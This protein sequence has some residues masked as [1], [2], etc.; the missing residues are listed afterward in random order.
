MNRI[1]AST[2]RRER[3]PLKEAPLSIRNC[4]STFAREAGVRPA[5]SRHC[6]R[7]AARTPLSQKRDGKA[8]A[9]ATIERLQRE[10]AV[11][12]ARVQRF[13]RYPSLFV[14][15]GVSPIWTAGSDSYISKLIELAG[16]LN[17]AGD[18]HAAYGQYSTEAL[19]RDQPD[20]LVVDPATRLDS[21][22]DREPWRSLRAVQRHQVYS[23]NPDILERPGAR[24]NEGLRWLLERIEPLAR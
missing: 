6:M 24:Y 16:G 9:P 20:L 4:R 21:I 22:T 12:T 11:L 17:A 13:A 1:P 14:V 23:V 18:L 2:Q 8:R 10:T 19:L 15:L 5:R 7:G 3:G